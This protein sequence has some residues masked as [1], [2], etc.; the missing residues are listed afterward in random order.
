MNI[1]HGKIDGI[2]AVSLQ[3]LENIYEIAIPRD[4]LATQELVEKITSISA[5]LN[6]EIA[7]FIDRRGKVVSVSVGDHSTVNLFSQTNRRSETSLSGLRCVHTHPNSS[8]RLSDL[9]LSALISLRLD[10]IIA[11]GINNNL[12]TDIYYAIPIPSGNNT[13]VSQSYGPIEFA[14]F[15][16]IDFSTLIGEIE[17]ELR[18]VT[19]D[20]GTG[21]EEER[22]ILIA[23]KND[24][25]TELEV[26]ASLKELEALAETAGL[27][28]LHHTFQKRDKP[29]QST[30]LGKGKILE[31]TLTVQSL[32][33]NVVICDDEITPSQQRNLES[34][35][36]IKV[37]DR[38][39][40]I[41]DIFAQRARSRE[42]KIQVELAQL[43]YLLPR[44]VGRGTAMSR[45]GGGIGTRGPGE[46]KLEIDRRNIRK[47]INDLEKDL[48]KISEQRHLLR[49]KR[50]ENQV[51]LVA[52]VGYTNAGKS[53]LTNKLISLSMGDKN[54]ETEDKM[55]FSADMLFATLDTTFRRVILEDGSNLIFVDTVGFINKLPHHLIKAFRATIEEAL[56]ADLLLHVVD[57]SSQY[58]EKQVSV[59]LQVL[60][61]LGTN[62]KP[63]ITA[64]NKIDLCKNDFNLPLANG[65]EVPVSATT[66]EGLDLL[67]QTIA[68][69][70][71]TRKVS[72]TFMFKY[73][74]GKLLNYLH[75]VGQVT[76]QQYCAEGTIVTANVYLEDYNRLEEH[77]IEEEI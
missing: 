43:N 47:R 1:I 49:K 8:G 23:Y 32:N 62:D 9:D 29:D 7:V 56:E 24:K 41:L 31:L 46:T 61:E 60:K 3:E 44:L 27:Q 52:L 12:P 73:D 22:A 15:E 53:S 76:S 20:N 25:T 66:G 34:L 69:S 11:I 71:P 74:E 64:I 51:P 19:K 70:L 75:S 48:H 72:G 63:V 45:L 50:R 40:L 55:V 33:A 35:L 17:S 26:N 54:S 67:L 18:R 13:I 28:V 10:T 39:V 59:V 57:G 14:K 36:G 30:Y 68:D 37:I 5:K 42:G 16:K 2:K 6:K 77:V 65:I 38:T 58:L 21:D 4:Q